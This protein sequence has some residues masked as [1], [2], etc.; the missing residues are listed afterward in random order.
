[1]RIFIYSSDKTSWSLRP[2]AYLFN[3]YWSAEAEVSVFGNSPLPFELPANFTFA[4]I[5]PF[6]PAREW[7]TDL[8]NALD[9]LDDDVICLL[10]DDYWIGRKV[11]TESIGLCYQYMLQHTDV[12]RFDICTDR[13]YARGMTDYGKL[14]HLDTIKSDPMSPYHFSYQ[15]SLWRRTTLLDCV[16]P[17]ETPWESEI[18]GDERLRKL[19]ALVLGTRQAPLR[20]TIAIQKGKFQPDG[21]YQTPAH[22]MNVE[23]VQ[24]I[25]AQGWIPA[26][27]L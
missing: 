25:E 23:D 24:Y 17:H 27:H 7:T 13:L 21:G 1:M 20:Y 8:R 3:R 9:A 18:R 22:A 12:A 16:V 15:A 5:G 4:S 2:F 26:E 6:L 14:G 11:D 19:G 10:M